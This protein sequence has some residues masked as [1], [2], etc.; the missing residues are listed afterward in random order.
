MKIVG[1]RGFPERFPENSIVGFEKAIEAGVDAVEC[2]IQFSD[3]GTPYLLH[4]LS[5]E[6]TAGIEK[7]ISE[8]SE[9]VLDELSVHE[10]A[11]FGLLYKPSPLPKL[12]A[13][14]ELLRQ[15][16]NITLFV[17]VKSESFAHID[18]QACVEKLSEVLQLIYQQVVI[19]SYDQELL[20]LA[21]NDANFP[22]GWVLSQFSEA[23]LRSASSLQPEYVICNKNKIPNDFDFRTSAWSWMIYDIV[24]PSEAH[25]FI[26]R[27]VEWIESWDVSSLR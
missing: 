19:I 17:E 14:V 1:H 21:R 8:M 15:H 3:R 13:L 6:R 18:R 7:N 5:L 12:S 24:E 16:P 22:V 2:D 20:R 23:A 11:R 9:L 27:G 26:Q 10:E 4:D 25:A